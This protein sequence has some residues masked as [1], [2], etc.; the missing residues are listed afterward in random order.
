[1]FV[2]DT[3][4][5]GEQIGVRVGSWK[6]IEGLAEGRRELY[7]LA[8]DPGERKNRFTEEPARAAAL[9]DRVQGF[10][11]AHPRP[12]SAPAVSPEDRERLR[13]LGYVE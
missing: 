8:R 7:D 4:V 6:Y 13:A 9:A 2:R 10:R 12:G 5:D 3:T 1:M 11:L